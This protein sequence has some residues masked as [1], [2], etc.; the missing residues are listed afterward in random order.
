MATSIT[1]SRFIR[2]CRG[3]TVDTTPVWIMRQAGRY[4]PEYR[5]V[6]A[7]TTFLGLCKDPELASEVTLQPLRRFPLDA[8][9]IFSDIL[10][11]VEA[12]G[13]ELH[14]DDGAGPRL[15]NPLTSQADVDKLSV[16][17]PVAKMGFVMDAI[18][19]VR[20]AKPE[21]PLIGFAGAPFTLASYMIEGKGSRDFKNAK[22]FMFR[23]P[24]TWRGLLE[25]VA[26]TVAAHLLA[27][28]E[29]GCSA[30]QIFDSWA[31]HL[32]PDDY[33]TYALPY[34]V[35]IIDQLKPKGVPIILFAKGVHA[36][37]P[38][39]SRSG[40]D[41]LGIDWTTPLDVARERTG[42]AVSLQGNMDPMALLAGPVQ[43]IERQVQR[44]LNEARGCRGH[45][46]NLGHGIIKD[47]DPAHVA[48]LVD[49]VHR[50]GASRVPPD[51]A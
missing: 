29:A 43:R 22:C 35:E 23:S 37:L 47:T 48:A 45:I 1:E 32:S 49:V 46:F 2:A 30:V 13:M 24:R 9:I 5:E 42:N 33:L 20:E 31:G 15:A 40:A 36:C 10:I 7:K 27:Q 18:R 25:K 21:T 19:A 26:K 4:L 11:P 12:M 51:L 50:E 6:R 16:P 14:F 8:G 44:V 38:Q 39:L 28:V 34:T 41:V 3:Q 17:D